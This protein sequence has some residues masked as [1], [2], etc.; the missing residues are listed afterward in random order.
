[1]MTKESDLEIWYNAI[2]GDSGGPMRCHRDK[3]A[4]IVTFGNKNCGVSNVNPGVYINV[5]NFTDWIQETMKK[6]I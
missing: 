2:Q 5:A 4:G 3:L 1:M 6:P